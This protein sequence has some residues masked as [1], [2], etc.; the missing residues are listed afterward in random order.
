MNSESIYIFIA[1]IL[2]IDIILSLYIFNYLKNFKNT[3]EWKRNTLLVSLLINVVLDIIVVL[4]IAF[5]P[6][7][8][9]TLIRKHTVAF[10]ILSVISIFATVFNAIFVFDYLEDIKLIECKSTSMQHLMYIIS[11]VA[12]IIYVITIMRITCL[13]NFLFRYGS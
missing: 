2:I 1:A 10:V 7:M 5:A 12:V 8:L 6:E 11:I 13:A 4:I 3:S 9:E